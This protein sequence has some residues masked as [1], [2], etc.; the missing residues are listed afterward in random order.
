MLGRL[1]RYNEI[2]FTASGGGY[3]LLTSLAG[4]I[5]AHAPGYMPYRVQAFALQ[6]LTTVAYTGTIVAGIYINSAPGLTATGNYTAIDSITLT[7]GQGSDTGQ[8]FYSTPAAITEV[9]P[10]NEVVLQLTGST[11]TA[12]QSHAIRATMFISQGEAN[13]GENTNMTAA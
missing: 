2:T 10:G 5:A 1:D 4:K 9:S 11:S 13:P 3:Y 7:S 6:H 8:V 12:S